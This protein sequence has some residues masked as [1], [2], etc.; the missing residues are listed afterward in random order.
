MVYSRMWHCGKRPRSPPKPWTGYRHVHPPLRKRNVSTVSMSSFSVVPGLTR[1]INPHEGP[2]AFPPCH[3]HGSSFE[4]AMHAM[5]EH[6][7][8]HL[9]DPGAQHLRKV[10]EQFLANRQ[11]P[12]RDFNLISP[13]HVLTADTMVQSLRY[14]PCQKPLIAV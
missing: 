1:S 3:S 5:H 8:P 6:V 10:T 13:P 9:S 2:N 11:L 4:K 12:S 7:V 14:V